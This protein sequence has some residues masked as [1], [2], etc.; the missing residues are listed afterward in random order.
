MTTVQAE[1]IARRKLS[2]LPLA[3][4]LGN[5]SK[6]CRIVGYSRQQ[7]LRDPAELSAA[8]RRRAHR[9][10]HIPSFESPR[11]PSLTGAYWWSGKVGE[12]AGRYA[13]P[14]AQRP[15]GCPPWSAGKWPGPVD[16]RELEGAGNRRLDTTRVVH[17]AL[18][19]GA[20]GLAGELR[21]SPG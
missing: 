19:A 8:R 7:F 15:P 20:L 17:A 1:K 9:G 18:R 10:L 13:T 12:A 11:D 21:R 2:L 14:P 16:I 4:E 5:V 3:Q 6:A